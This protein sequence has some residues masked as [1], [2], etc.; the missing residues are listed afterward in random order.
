MTTT[1]QI[2][3]PPYTPP[4]KRFDWEDEETLVDRRNRLPY[5]IQRF[6]RRIWLPALIVG[7]IV[8][9]LLD[10]EVMGTVITISGFIFQLL[11][12]VSYIIFQFVVMF[13]FLARTRMYVVMPGAEGVG[14]KDYRGQPEIL[15]QAEQIVTLL[16]G[17]KAFENS[18]GEPLTG[19]LLEGPPGTGKTWL[20]Q[21]ISTEAGVP[22]FYLDASSLQA[23][24]I[25]VG[26]MKMM[27]LY[28]RARKAA[29]EY[30][31]A[32]IFLDEIDSIGGSRGGVAQTGGGTGGP[33]GMGGM[34]GGGDMGLLSTMLIEMSGFS[35]E[36]GWR[37]KLRTWWYKTILRR[38]PPPIP[39]RVLTIGATNRVRSLDPALLRP[40]RFDKKI[41]I[42]APDQEGRRDIIE[43][44]LSKMT[45]DATMD[46]GIL[47]SETPGYTPADLKYLLNEAL[48]YAFFDGRREMTY[49]DFRRAQ[50]E[51]EMGIRSPLKHMSHEARERVAYH[52][53]GHAV[54]VRL[55]LPENRIARITIIRQGGAFGHVLHFPARESYQGMRTK[56]V[57]MNLLRVSVAGKAAEIE[58]CGQGNQTLGVGGDF[59]KIRNNL[60]AI[61][62]AG[63]LGPLG[64][65]V[66]I[67]TDLFQPGI[68]VT[69]EMAE[70]MEVT[71]QAVL[72]ETRVALRERTEMVHE[73]VKLLMEREELLADEVEAFFD[74]YGL[75]T[76]KPSFVRDGKEIRLI[77]PEILTPPPQSVASN[78]S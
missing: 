27:R 47:A 20:A 59:S 21:A 39:K 55:F 5:R 57:W 1:N 31:A 56:E 76:P 69:K 77:P 67:S 13:W 43:Y 45:H 9:A 48:R 51:H 66:G 68:R 29:K 36:H 10:A 2:P 49:R 4:E 24:F 26:P 6:V 44:Y 8:L 37:A 40:G 41:R 23:M 54:A 78:N 16:R 60:Y 33:G 61:A 14:F 22:Y 65:A 70:Q 15:E 11:F 25:G 64:G 63:M 75:H 38:N 46:P 74:R 19:L 58:F 32:V 53:A 7:I 18:G 12:V 30:G 50:P 17:V 28:A 3:K 34:F 72:K 62:M 52:E 35:L 73:L 42:D 71:F